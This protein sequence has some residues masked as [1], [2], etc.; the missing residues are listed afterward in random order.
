MHTILNAWILAPGLMPR[1]TLARSL[2]ENFYEE[3]ICSA[4]AG[5]LACKK[6]VAWLFCHNVAVQRDLAK[7]IVDRRF[8][9]KV[10]Q[11]GEAELGLTG[12]LAKIS[13]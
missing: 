7:V 8:E 11:S 10:L 3:L 9:K 2:T 12:C 5:L 4:I 1:D 13:E 6:L